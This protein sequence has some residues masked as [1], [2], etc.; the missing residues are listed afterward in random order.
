M[1]ELGPGIVQQGDL[2]DP[3][4][5][6]FISFAQYAT[7]NREISQDPPQVFNEQK[8]V[9]VAENEPQQFTSVI[10]K[11]DPNLTNQMLAPTH[12]RLV[13]S[14]VLDRLEETF[15]NTDI[16]LPK[17]SPGSRPDDTTV[18]SL[19]SQLV[20]LFLINGYAWDGNASMS[21]F[22]AT[23]NFNGDASGT[24]FT[25]TLTSPA[26]IWSSQALQLR[27]RAAF[28]GGLLNTFLLTTAK[29]LVRRLGY[30]IASSS[31]TF[32][33]NKETSSFTIK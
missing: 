19:I 9:E 10:V 2:T 14:A 7:I 32:E 26:T 21:K 12:S 15:G 27:N 29:E 17:I 24:Q 33:G 18:L 16:S 6:D 20:K 30:D 23:E 1:N 5:F 28:G 22:S 25:I 13:A 8:P 11:R 4:Y 3:Y 31:V